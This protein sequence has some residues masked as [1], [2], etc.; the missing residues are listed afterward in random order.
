M[1]PQSPWSSG[2][3]YFSSSQ[4]SSQVSVGGNSRKTQQNRHVQLQ[5]AKIQKKKTETRSRSFPSHQS[6]R[7]PRQR[8]FGSQPSRRKS[9][10]KNIGIEKA[11]VIDFGLI[12]SN[13]GLLFSANK[14]RHDFKTIGKTFTHSICK[15]LQDDIQTLF[16]FKK[17]KEKKKSRPGSKGLF[18]RNE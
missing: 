6:K 3:S 8:S 12:N 16:G 18:R 7:E 10:K 14:M 5:L 11:G 1:P 9:S 13:Q 4:G 15:P 17:T 2:A